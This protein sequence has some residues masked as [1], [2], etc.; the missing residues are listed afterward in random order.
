MENKYIAGCDP[1]ASDSQSLSNIDQIFKECGW[2]LDSCVKGVGFYTH[3]S[4]NLTVEKE[5]VMWYEKGW[6][7]IKDLNDESDSYE[8]PASE[9][10]KLMKTL[11][12]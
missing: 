5:W 12:I 8:V 3:K 1:I 11:G 4:Y 10:I 2:E 6:I 7:E 9:L